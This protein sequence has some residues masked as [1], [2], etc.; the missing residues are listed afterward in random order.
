MKNLIR[1]I[2]LVVFV[3]FVLALLYMHFS[4]LGVSNASSS[5]RIME[6]KGRIEGRSTEYQSEGDYAARGRI[7]SEKMKQLHYANDLDRQ[8]LKMLEGNFPAGK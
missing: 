2:S 1:Q 6:L 3:I 7:A 5:D 4:S 8:E